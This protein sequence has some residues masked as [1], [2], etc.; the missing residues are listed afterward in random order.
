MPTSVG[1]GDSAK[2]DIAETMAKMVQKQDFYSIGQELV[3]GGN[4]SL[5]SQQTAWVQEGKVPSPAAVGV[6]LSKDGQDRVCFVHIPSEG[7]V[8]ML[9]KTDL[10]FSSSLSSSSSSACGVCACCLPGTGSELLCWMGQTRR[11]Q[12]S[13]VPELE[14]AD[15]KEASTQPGPLKEGGLATFAHP[16][17][18][19]LVCTGIAWASPGG[20]ASVSRAWC[21]ERSSEH[22]PGHV[23]V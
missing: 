9:R 20:P 16:R 8:R 23:L 4:L 6:V 13:C 11:T 10:S 2:E 1:F 5:G 7:H 21:E 12:G 14:K 22:L 17:R 19:T 15:P 18:I 3:A